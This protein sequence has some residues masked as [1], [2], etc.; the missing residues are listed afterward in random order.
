LIGCN[1][2]NSP[3]YNIIKDT[4]MA[5][6]N[7]SVAPTNAIEIHTTADA[8][9]IPTIR[10][11]ATQLATHA[12]FETNSIDDLR[13]AVDEA[14]AQLVQISPPHA[15]LSCIFIVRADRI[16]VAAEAPVDNPI[17]PLPTSSL[18]WRVLEYLA[19]DLQA[20]VVPGEAGQ[21]ARAC[22]TLTKAAVTTRP[23]D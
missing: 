9:A 2:A 8:S 19:D 17:E 20:V 11:V 6:E 15:T 10:A 22:I 1:A 14:C 4:T 12:G 16:V 13:I 18:G 7:G 23:W 21:H 5:C 3:T